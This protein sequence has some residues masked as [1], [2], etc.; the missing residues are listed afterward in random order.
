MCHAP[1]SGIYPYIIA[2][3]EARRN[4]RKKCQANLKQQ[5]QEKNHSKLEAN[6]G[7]GKKFL[8]GAKERNITTMQEAI[9]QKVSDLKSENKYLLILT[10]YLNSCTP[11]NVVITSVAEA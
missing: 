9:R 6:Q 4:K 7:K 2:A 5:R 11:D 8:G 10:P 1:C 3:Q